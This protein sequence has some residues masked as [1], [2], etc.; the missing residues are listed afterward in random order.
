MWE[1]W[2]LG[3]LGAGNRLR[4]F[5]KLSRIE[6]LAPDGEGH[7][8]W[9]RK[10]SQGTPRAHFLCCLSAP[11]A[12]LWHSSLPGKPFCPAAPPLSIL[13]SQRVCFDSC[14]VTHAEKLWVHEHSWLW[15]SGLKGDQGWAGVRCLID[16]LQLFS[17]PPPMEHMFS[18]LSLVMLL[19]PGKLSPCVSLK[20][21]LRFIIHVIST[22]ML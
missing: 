2:L 22:Y 3:R 18:L 4:C 17:F 9:P 16:N 1:R 5:R 7:A 11:A 6:W 14:G 12:S 21:K 8:P 10:W 15:V 13:V 19:S 20:A